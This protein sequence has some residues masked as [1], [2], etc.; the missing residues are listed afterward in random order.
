[1]NKYL[2]TEKLTPSYSLFKSQET[3]QNIAFDDDD[4]DYLE[5]DATDFTHCILTKMNLSNDQFHNCHFIEVVFVNCDLSNISFDNTLLR[6]CTFIDC[7]MIGTA[8]DN[9]LLE[10]VA[11]E[12]C[13]ENY[14][15]LA[16]TQLR[17]VSFK[18]CDLSEA[19]LSEC[20]FKN[21]ELKQGFNRQTV[22]FTAGVIPCRG[23]T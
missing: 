21:T 6:R 22:K 19:Y 5:I 18:A 11:F 10:Y 8:F 4:F 17:T 16:R 12:N 3:M 14:M 20:T 9:C 1:M 15:N 23:K 2:I 13:K 7:K